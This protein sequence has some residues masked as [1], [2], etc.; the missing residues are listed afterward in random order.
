MAGLFVAVPAT[1]VR[2]CGPL[3]VASISVATDAKSMKGLLGVG[4]L[5]FGFVHTR[6][7]GAGLCDPG[8]AVIPGLVAAVATAN[9]LTVGVHR[10]VTGDA[11]HRFEL[12]VTLVTESYW[13][14]LGRQRDH[15]HIGWNRLRCRYAR[16]YHHQ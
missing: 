15:S 10:V 8:N 2:A 3:L 16:R 7:L 9:R 14:K 11:T 1:V 13:T 4:G 6:L 12:A 5:W